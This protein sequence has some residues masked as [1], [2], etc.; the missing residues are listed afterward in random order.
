V[1]FYGDNTMQYTNKVALITGASSGIGKAISQEL[2]SRGAHVILIARNRQK[3]LKLKDE[4]FGNGG[5]ASCFPCDITDYDALGSLF[6]ALQAEF[7]EIHLLVNNAGKE[8]MSPLQ[9]TSIKDMRDVIELNV[10]AMSFVIKHCLK[11]LRPGSSIVNMASAAGIQGAAGMSSYCASKGAVIALTRSL[12]KELAPRKVRVNAIAPGMVKTD[13]LSR[14]FKNFSQE[15][16][17]VIEKMHPLGFG[18]PL[19]IANGVAF[20]GSD[21]ASWLT[22]HTL[23]IDGGLTA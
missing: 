3:L 7:K 2:A 20:I 19:D 6:K 5:K 23:V 22:G 9:A 18:D 10:I 1:K 4:I 12:A 16:V 15:Q 11:L 13:L 17:S 21:E 8:L 14:L